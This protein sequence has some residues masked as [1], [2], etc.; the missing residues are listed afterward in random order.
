MGVSSGPSS[1]AFPVRSAK[2][3]PKIV[4]ILTNATQEVYKKYGKE[5]EEEVMRLDAYAH[6]LDSRKSI[7]TFNEEDDEVTYKLAEEFGVRE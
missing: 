5:I 7:Q 2:T 3:P 6:F 4:D 1:L